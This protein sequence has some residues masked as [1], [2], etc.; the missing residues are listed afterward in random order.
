MGPNKSE[1]LKY[2]KR[3]LGDKDF[4]QSMM[5]QSLYTGDSLGTD[6]GGPPSTADTK[7]KNPTKVVITDTLT[8][9]EILDNSNTV[10]INVD[11]SISVKNTLPSKSTRTNKNMKNAFNQ[12]RL[13]K[14]AILESK[15]KQIE[16]GL[17]TIHN[18]W[19]REK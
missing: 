15:N 7:N 9:E 3:S 6:G 10:T 14:K 11:R 19:Y 5:S 13:D 1:G 8:N 2:I 18:I 16:E 17:I 12:E 4:N